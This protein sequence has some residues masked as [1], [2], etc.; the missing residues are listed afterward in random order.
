MDISEVRIKLVENSKE[1]LRAFCSITLDQDFV[2]RDLKIIDGS[3]GPFVAMPSRKLADRC[4]QCGYKNHLRARFCNECGG[5]LKENRAPKD[6]Q[7]RAKLHADVAH[8]INSAC[9]DLIQKTVIE[10]YLEELELSKQPDY[11]PKPYD[12]MDFESE[13]EEETMTA[14]QALGKER[15]FNE[16]NELIA[17][18]KKD[19]AGRRHSHDRQRKSVSFFEPEE[20]R[21]RVFA[22]KS[23][24]SSNMEADSAETA[25]EDEPAW[26]ARQ[27]AQLEQ[28]GQPAPARRSPD[29][30]NGDDDFGAGIL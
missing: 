14:K 13:Y 19:A 15:S 22:E 16:Y 2:V 5:R 9:R 1:R 11:Q 27:D 4:Q 30:G 6:M 8:P 12:D 25:R 18:L 7:G 26:P 29:A 28:Q 23:A 17:D 24:G 10:A 21:E 20:D 3:N